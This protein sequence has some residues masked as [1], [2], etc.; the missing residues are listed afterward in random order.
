MINMVFALTKLSDMLRYPLKAFIAK[1]V[2]IS[3]V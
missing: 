1:V 3:G 2:P